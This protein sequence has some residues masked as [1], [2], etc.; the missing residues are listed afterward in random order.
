MTVCPECKGKGFKP[1][2]DMQKHVKV[3]KTYTIGAT[4]YRYRSCFNC[5]Y[6]WQTAENFFKEVHQVDLFS[7]LDKAS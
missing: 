7:D 1:K 2:P 3:V 4:T 5:G 6:Q